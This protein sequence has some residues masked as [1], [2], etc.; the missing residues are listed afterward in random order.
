MTHSEVYKQYELQMADYWK[1]TSIW[2]PNG[3]NSIR[4]RLMDKREYI[5]TYNGPFD[6]KFETLNNFLKNIKN[7][8]G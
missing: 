1:I 3:K 2:F 6:W 8:K 4:V 5:F 7:S